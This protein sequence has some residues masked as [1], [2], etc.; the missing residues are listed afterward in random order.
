[1]TPA[2]RQ[3]LRHVA[4]LLKLASHHLL[5][6]ADDGQKAVKPQARGRPRIEPAVWQVAEVLRLRES[7]GRLGYRAIGEKV[8]LSWLIV[9]R[10][11]RENAASQKGVLASQKPFPKSGGGS[12]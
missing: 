1:V 4:Q 7:N 12:A 10:I 2:E 9:E 5:E 6:L 11:I 3:R 8:G